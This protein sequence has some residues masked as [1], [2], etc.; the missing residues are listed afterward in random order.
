M[1]DGLTSALSHSLRTE[2][3]KRVP[4]SNPHVHPEYRDP[5]SGFYHPSAGA[6]NLAKDF[7]IAIIRVSKGDVS[8]RVGFSNVEYAGYVHE[9]QDPHPSG[10]PVE[11]STPN[12]GNKF[13]ETP[14]NETVDRVLEDLDKNIV[15]ALKRIRA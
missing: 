8:A 1:A 7:D 9:M 10:N 13:L 2:V 12:T 3:M 5:K 15:H 11:W 4:R 6:G 14:V